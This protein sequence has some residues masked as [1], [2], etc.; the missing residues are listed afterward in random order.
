MIKP[1][2][3]I[4]GNQIKSLK[5]CRAALMQAMTA[6]ESID[7]LPV[8]LDQ[9]SNPE[10]LQPLSDGLQLFTKFAELDEAAQ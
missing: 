3:L 5:N 6:Y 2:T 9:K 7:G 8:R 10:H 4:A 1:L